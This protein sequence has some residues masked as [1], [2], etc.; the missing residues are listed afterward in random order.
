[1]MDRRLLGCVLLAAVV[2]G[3]AVR[4]EDVPATPTQPAVEKPKEA[5]PADA[6]AAEPTAAD[7]EDPTK[8][9]GAPPK[10]PLESTKY[11]LIEDGYE[12]QKVA[13]NFDRD[14]GQMEMEYGPMEDILVALRASSQEHLKKNVNLD[15]TFNMLMKESE[16]YRGE[17]VRFEGILA[18]MKEINATP[19][20]SGFDK[21]WKGQTTSA[22]GPIIS[23]RCVEPLPPNVKVGEPVAITGIFMKRFC[24]LNREPG[25]KLTWTPLIFV[26]RIEPYSPIA[27]K[28]TSDS[29]M[30]NTIG[31]SIFVFVGLCAAAWCYSRMKSKT[32]GTNHFS[33]LKAEKEGKGGFFPRK[34]NR[35]P[36]NKPPPPKPKGEPPP[37]SGS[38][39]SPQ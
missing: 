18:E 15:I 9:V 6:A 2:F 33:N 1:M 29:S 28:V 37:T 8:I 10:F 38:P 5:A 23:F 31:I 30:G 35:P 21:L 36:G 34:N 26:R 16:K 24:Y 11:N 17:V 25:E 22:L 13:E 4:A 19:N 14:K 12:P 32:T 7:L 3:T 39:A 27:R 20:L